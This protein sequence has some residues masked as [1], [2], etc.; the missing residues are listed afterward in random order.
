MG[1]STIDKMKVFVA[2]LFALIQSALAAEWHDAGIKL[3]TK[4]MACYANSELYDIMMTSSDIMSQ[5]HDDPGKYPN[6]KNAGSAFCFFD[7]LGFF[8]DD[9]MKINWD[10]VRSSTGSSVLLLTIARI[11]TTILMVASGT[12]L[13]TSSGEKISTTALLIGLLII[14]MV[15]LLRNCKLRLLINLLPNSMPNALPIKNDIMFI[16]E[17]LTQAF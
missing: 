8:N 14:S 6:G 13:E 15:A 1:Q 16:Y 17:A 9:K 10:A 4:Q 5:C 12:L 3:N 11:L 7:K 2:V